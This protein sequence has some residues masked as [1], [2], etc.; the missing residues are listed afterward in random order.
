EYVHG[1]ADVDGRPLGVIHRDVTP[2][3]IMITAS[4]A[5]KL[6]DFGIVRAAVQTHQT[7]SGVVKG[8]FSY[9]A[10]EM[11][12]GIPSAIDHRADLFATGIT[13]QDRKSTRLNSS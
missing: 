1:L 10:P 7:R 6:I 8:K 9:M 3:N 11:L 2:Q 13:L 4:G 5:V 12:R